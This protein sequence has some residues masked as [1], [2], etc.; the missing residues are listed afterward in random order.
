M[1]VI[2][3][4]QRLCEQLNEMQSWNTKIDNGGLEVYKRNKNVVEEGLFVSRNTISGVQQHHL[5]ITPNP[6]SADEVLIN[7]G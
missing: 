1:N 6:Q 4:Q 7:E 5:R 3:C 2:H